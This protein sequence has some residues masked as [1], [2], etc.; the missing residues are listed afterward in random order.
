LSP[1]VNKGRPASGRSSRELYSPATLEAMSSLL[2]NSSFNSNPI[3]SPMSSTDGSGSD[4]PSHEVLLAMVKPA[5][6]NL[7]PVP[8]DTASAALALLLRAG[9][10]TDVLK[11]GSALL[12][13]ADEQLASY[14]VQG[15]GASSSSLRQLQLRRDVAV[16]VALA[17]I[18]R[19]SA[20]AEQGGGASPACLEAAQGHLE[21]ALQLLVAY[22]AAPGLQQELASSLQAVVV[23]AATAVLAATPP[24]A[25]GGAP[26]AAEQG[27]ASDAAAQARSRALESLRCAL[28]RPATGSLRL[29]GLRGGAAAEAGEAEAGRAAGRGLGSFWPP[30]LTAEERCELLEPL[31]GML[32]AAEH[33]RGGR[34]CGPTACGLGCRAA[35]QAGA[36]R[37]RAM[38]VGPAAPPPPA[39]RAVGHRGGRL[40]AAGGGGAVGAGAA[41]GLGRGAS[42]WDRSPARGSR[43]PALPVSWGQPSR[44]A[45]VTSSL[46]PP[47]LLN[48]PPLA[49]P[50]SCTTWPW[51]TS[52]RGWPPDGRSTCCRWAP[53][54]EQQKWQ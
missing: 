48:P 28:W 31:R 32:T 18:S 13:R 10:V 12:A 38:W 1:G 34:A 45:R 42:G 2:H 17:H 44:F 4:G 49:N 37:G 20:E 35:V 39:D 50:R 52:P 47:P 24:V 43:P 7:A 11:A 9:C 16:S 54:R 30:A 46:T 23:A 15:G 8:M 51:R 41:G 33:V 22:G 27:S 53:R 40:A 26:E 19:A 25:A 21:S 3:G 14:T 6:G 5:S 36:G 29:G